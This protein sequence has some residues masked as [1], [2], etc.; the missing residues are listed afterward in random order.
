MIINKRNNSQ[1]I[2]IELFE[3]F[4]V[5]CLFVM[6]SIWLLYAY[7]LFIS[8][9]V[10]RYEITWNEIYKMK[11]SDVVFAE[12]NTGISHSRMEPLSL[13]VMWFFS[14]YADAMVTFFLVGLTALSVKAWILY[15]NVTYPLI[16]L[17]SYVLLFMQLLE[18]NQIRNAL[19]SCFILYALTS[20]ST[21]PRYYLLALF[22]ALFHYTGVIILALVLLE[23][24]HRPILGILGVFALAIIWDIAMT[25]IG[26]NIYL[27]YEASVNL[28]STVF[29]CHIGIVFFSII[30]WKNLNINQRRG[31]YFMI[32]GAAFYIAFEGNPTI[33]HRM[34]ELCTLGLIPLLFMS[35]KK[36][37]YP[38]LISYLLAAYMAFYNATSGLSRLNEVAGIF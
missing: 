23:R 16:A 24:F 29:I 7:V 19:A 38:M 17:C 10:G 22:A 13:A 12:R 31:A 30:N 33:A 18:A 15:K 27:S 37:N 20:N 34:R 6:T 25:Y 26:L 32:L 8:V 3:R 2:T 9:D 21:N 5:F 4:F 14:Q 35:D 28:F 36:L 1:I 11:L